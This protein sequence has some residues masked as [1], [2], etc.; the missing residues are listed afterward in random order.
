MEFYLTPSILIKNQSNY[1]TLGVDLPNLKK[2]AFADTFKST[3]AYT[4]TTWFVVGKGF[5]SSLNISNMNY[6]P[7]VYLHMLINN[8]ADVTGEEE[9][10]TLSLGS[11][12]LSKL[13]DEEKA[14]A[15]NKG[16]VLE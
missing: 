12:L 4:D 15:T 2:I 8:L 6:L 3:S 14:I 5:K 16:W 11:T 10:Y 13:S 9:T 7:G 1:F